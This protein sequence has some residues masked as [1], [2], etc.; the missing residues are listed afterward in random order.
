M[1]NGFKYDYL[2]KLWKIEKSIGSTVDYSHDWSQWLSTP[3]TD[4]IISSTWSI[5]K[6]G[7]TQTTSIY[8]DTLATVFLSGGVVGDSYRVTNT[9]TT[10]GGRTETRTFLVKVVSGLSG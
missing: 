10:A 3:D 5:N 2:K 8:T 6:S 1:K 7:L 4:R 9:I